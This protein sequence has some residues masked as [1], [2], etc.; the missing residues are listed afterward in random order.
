MRKYNMLSRRTKPSLI[1]LIAFAFFL[2]V[3][4]GL[5]QVGVDEVTVRAFDG[6]AGNK[7]LVIWSR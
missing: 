2:F 4:A 3:F 1:A 5:A 6:Q 7:M